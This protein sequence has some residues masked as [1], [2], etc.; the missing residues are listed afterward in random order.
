MNQ[1]I[2][3]I[4]GA[5][6]AP[7]PPGGGM[8]IN[9]FLIG[10]WR[11]KWLI[12]ASTLLFTAIFYRQAQYIIPLYKTSTTIQTRTYDKDATRLMETD[13]LIEM[14]SRMFYEQLTAR[15][16]LALS[17]AD[18]S[19]WENNIFSEF[20]TTTSPTPGKYRM[21]IDDAGRFYLSF[22]PEG[23]RDVPL[24]SCS[25]WDV[26]DRSRTIN[27]FTFRLKNEFVESNKEKT[28]RIK[29]FEKA[30]NELNG[31][32]TPN[33]NGRNGLIVLTMTGTDPEVLQARLNHIAEVYVR[34]GVGL[35]ERDVSRERRLLETKKDAAE[36]LLK[37]A[38]GALRSFNERYPLSLDF[39]R[40]TIADQLGDINAQLRVLPIQREKI[41]QLMERLDSPGPGID[42]EQFRQFI[43]SELCNCEP[44]NKE[45]SLRVLA[46]QLSSQVN[47]MPG[48][49]ARVA[50]DSKE[51]KEHK[52]KIK[53][54]QDDILAFASRY[55]TVLAQMEKEAR[56]RLAGVK[57][58]Q[59][60]LPADETTLAELQRRKK[61]AEES[62]DSILTELQRY[63]LRTVEGEEVTIL[64]RAGRPEST[65]TSKVKK[66][67]IGA[68][69]GLLLGLLISAGIDFMDKTIRTVSD[70]EHHLKLPVL[71]AIPVVDFKGIP[72]YHDFEKAKHID[73]QLVT[74][75]YSPTPIGEAY[76]ALR[77]QIL[78]SKN[79][80]RIHTLVITS[81]APEDG[82]SFTASNLA[83]IF[84][85]QRTNTLLV[86]A[87]LRRGVLHNT[88]RMKKEPGLAN[89]LSGSITLSEAV[90]QTHIPNLS[91][92]SYGTLMP[93]PSELLGSLQMQRFLNEVKRKF[94]LILFDSPP[95][96]A[97]TDAV[98][99]GTQVDGVTVVVRSGKTNRNLAKDKLDI[100]TSVPANLIGS[101]LNGAD[102]VLVQNYSY[103]HY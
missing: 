37:E 83:I 73:K 32:V 57:L 86:D 69:L 54:S 48:L 44:M 64:E 11:R 5:S 55:L 76:R 99:I 63:D 13:R 89:Y 98:V 2:E 35:K 17:L 96:E 92:I 52:A 79:R 93:N 3:D 30:I 12:L 85:Q 7:A 60:Q 19:I 88:F 81:I 1:Y 29:P 45:P 80:E 46:A 39:E 68:G 8:D 21:R 70:V 18:G 33:F 36:K 47:E 41:T 91:F 15:M 97:A 101:I 62:Y 28:F 74:H 43:V 78:F 9:K 40:K 102:T 72:E 67:A 42:P 90:Q 95:L 100:F 49:A 4:E 59:R 66:I 26:V 22:V 20:S 31:S 75:D 50:K 87:D 61:I 53:Q 65:T 34:E 56:D 25:V 27:G 71:G 16:G 82:K 23:G 94:D 14:K 58:Q 6:A 24:D 51:Y 10:F 84:A 103:Y 38:E 77:T